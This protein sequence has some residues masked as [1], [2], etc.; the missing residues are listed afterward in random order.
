MLLERH[1]TDKEE[2]DAKIIIDLTRKMA[3]A[4][5]AS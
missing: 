3:N 5:N 2:A 4:E 1:G